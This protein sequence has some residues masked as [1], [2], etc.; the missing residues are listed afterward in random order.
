MKLTKKIATIMTA[1]LLATTFAGQAMAADGSWQQNSTGWWYQFADKTYPTN[2][3]LLD[4][5]GLWYYFDG[6]G[7][8]VTGRQSIDGYLFDFNASG[9]MTANNIT[10]DNVEKEMTEAVNNYRAAKGVAGLT[11]ND[12]L[13]AAAATRVQEL[14][15]MF[16]NTR[17]NGQ[18][19]SSAI[20]SAGYDAKNSTELILAGDNDPKAIVDAWAAS[21]ANRA[22]L[23]AGYSDMGFAYVTT[24]GGTY[25]VMLLAN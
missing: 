9:A 17:P 13:M 6:N 23:I 10:K 5:N 25:W 19:F 16:S 15:S 20:K 3:W 24:E 22:K 21:D 7:Y 4:N 12:K 11:Q 18:K 14:T 2:S 8:M 1:A